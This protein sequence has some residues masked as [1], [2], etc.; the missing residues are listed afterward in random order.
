MY[1]YFN[2]FKILFRLVNLLILK[3]DYIVLKDY[4]I[5]V[6]L[7]HSQIHAETLVLTS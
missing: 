7:M 3:L 2:I 1:I 4:S 6:Y 5:S